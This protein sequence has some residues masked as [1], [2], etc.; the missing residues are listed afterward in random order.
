MT[1]SSLHTKANLL[2]SQCAVSPVTDGV[3]DHEVEADLVGDPDLREGTE[4]AVA[5]GADLPER[6]QM[7]VASPGPNLRAR[8]SLEQDLGLALDEGIFLQMLPTKHVA[9]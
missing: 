4:T 6:G 2:T 7:T 5:Q 3:H 9:E 1:Q 8:A